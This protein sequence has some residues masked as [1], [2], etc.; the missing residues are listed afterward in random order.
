MMWFI[1]TIIYYGYKKHTRAL[2]S[3]VNK[4]ASIIK[5]FKETENN[6]DHFS[7]DETVSKNNHLN[8][9]QGTAGEDKASRE[10]FGIFCCG[11]LSTK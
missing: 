6:K 7:L 2:L 5:M 3:L 1:S 8:R 10:V 9:V 4:T 11:S